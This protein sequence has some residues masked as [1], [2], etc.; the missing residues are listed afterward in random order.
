MTAT[1]SPADYRGAL[2]WTTGACWMG[3][4]R[5]AVEVRWIG[6][7]RFNGPYGLIDT[8]LFACADCIDRLHHQAVAELHSTR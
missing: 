7:A 2:G 3:C 8:K 1:A 5:T 6:P 4:Q